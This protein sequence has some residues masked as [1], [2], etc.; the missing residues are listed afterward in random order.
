[1][2]NFAFEEEKA[3]S[4]FNL[5]VWRK[6]LRY[7]FRNWPLLIVLALSMLLTTFYDSSFMPLMNAAAIAAIPE[8]PLGQSVAGMIINVELIFG[9]RFTLD[10]VGFALV[11]GAGILIR[12]ISIFVTFFVT[13]YF[14]MLINTSLR[15]DAFRRAQELSFSYYDRTPSG[16]LIARMQNDT[17]AISDTLSWGVI[18]I[19]WITFEL[20]FTLITMFSRDVRLSLIILSIAP[21]LMIVAPIF[22]RLLLKAQRKARSAYSNFVRWLVECI[23]GVKTIKTLNI[24]EKMYEEADDVTMNIYVKRRKAFKIH[25]FFMPVI[26]ILSAATTALVILL[27]T[28]NFGLLDAMTPAGVATLVLF[29]GFVSQIYNPIQEFSEVANE[30]IETQAKVEKVMSLIETKPEIVDTPEVVAKYGTLFDNKKENFEPL[31]GDL[32]FEHV[33]FSYVKDTEVIHDLN[34]HIKQGTS[35]AIV[36]E[37]GSGKSTTANLLCRF[38]EPTTG[39]ILVDGIDYKE[40]SVGWLRSNIGY[41]QQTP[42]VFRASFYDNVRYGRPEASLEEVIEACKVVGVH[43]FIMAQKD[44]YQTELD[45]GGSQLSGGQKQLISF[46]RAIIRNPRL[47]ILDEATSSIDT[48]SE[49]VIQSAMNKILQGRTSIIIAH[50]LS[51]IVNC[52]RILVM[53]EGKIIEDGSHCELMSRKGHYHHLYMNQF[54]ELNLESQIATY[55]EQIEKMDVKL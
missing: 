53:S 55:E 7:T 44:G 48:E 1:M 2:A 52:D 19:V 32:V 37:T 29:I 51:T 16:W 24:E 43:D 18:R 40:R 49:G 46:A 42:F 25:A 23:N 3:P 41:V 33:S 11:F 50:R 12:S 31:N 22:Q 28:A 30:F 14:D 39:R 17:S 34:L 9:I 6:M 8:I 26:N 20:L 47:L 36:G 10:F 35:L 15:R 27:A 13:N 54:R 45:D 21:L 5:G 4:K 38:Y